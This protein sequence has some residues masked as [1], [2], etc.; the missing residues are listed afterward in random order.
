MGLKNSQ[1]R[2]DK[3]FEKIQQV[4][5]A[6]GA[7][8]IMFDYEGGV[9]T[10]ISFCI[11]IGGKPISFVLPA[12]IENVTQIMYGGKDRYGRTKEITKLQREQ[13]FKTGWAN[14]RDWVDAQMALI[15]TQQVQLFQVF[16]PYA[17]TSTG[18]TLFEKVIENPQFLL[19]NGKE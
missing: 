7:N 15:D 17:V 18:A 5:S 12:L 4:L 3:S 19:G 14:I 16:L 2:T 11:D 10:K 9:A 13:A 1:S 8:K 6:H